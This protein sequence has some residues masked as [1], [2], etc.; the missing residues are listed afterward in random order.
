LINI[1]QFYQTGTGSNT[2]YVWPTFAVAIPNHQQVDS[3][4]AGNDFTIFIRNGSAYSFG[5][6]SV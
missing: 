2:D 5:L 3:I 6:N 4:H 1:E